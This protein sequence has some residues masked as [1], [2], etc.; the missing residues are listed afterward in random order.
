VRLLP[1]SAALSRPAH[2]TLHE[3]R[4]CSP[5]DPVRAN[6]AAPRA[7]ARPTFAAAAFVLSQL[8][9]WGAPPALLAAML[10]YGA[11]DPHQPSTARAPPFLPTAEAC[12][13]ARVRP[14]ALLLVLGW[15]LATSGLL[16]WRLA[17]REA[18]MALRS[19][20]PPYPRVGGCAPPGWLGWACHAAHNT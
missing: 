10:P 13:L 8:A 9:A 16:T 15:L 2:A 11:A 7:P 12:G 6:L 3:G 19:L 5:R 4:C 18:D 14:R 17:A 20:L 1:G